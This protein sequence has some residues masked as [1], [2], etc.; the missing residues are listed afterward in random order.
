MNGDTMFYEI[1][2]TDKIGFGDSTKSVSLIFSSILKKD[3]FKLKLDIQ[4]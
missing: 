1:D 4:D 2:Y 3:K